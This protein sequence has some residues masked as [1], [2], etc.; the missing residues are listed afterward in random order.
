[1]V[2]RMQKRLAFTLIELLVVI[3]IIAI[4]IGLLLPAV[5]KVREAAARAKCENQLKQIAL[6]A[7]NYASASTYLPPGWMGPAP[8]E[9]APNA[10]CDSVGDWENNG[11]DVSSLTLLL[12]YLEQQNLYGQLV[13]AGQADGYPNFFAMNQ[14]PF[15]WWEWTN[16][17]TLA[18]TQIPT[19]ICPSD[20]PY[21]RTGAVFFLVT[22]EGINNGLQITGVSFG[23]TPYPYG[24]TNYLGVGGMFGNTANGQ[25]GGADPNYGYPNP[26]MIQQFQGLMGNRSKISLE[27]LT[28]ADGSANTLMYGE[29]CGDSDYNALNQGG[30]AL[31]WMGC[32]YF[33]T[34]WGLPSGAA[35]INTWYC[36]SSRHSNVVQ[37]AMGD[38]AVRQI[39]KPYQDILQ[40]GN[41]LPTGNVWHTVNAVP[42]ATWQLS[43]Y[44]GWEEGFYLDPSFIGN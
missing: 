16:F 9:P 35:S 28:S 12:P 1:M 33:P 27:Q 17:D 13:A 6:A 18:Q 43:A 4:L 41:V 39:K 8:N 15:G 38:G 32:G 36:F 34:A 31:S 21:L 20:T 30:F 26:M 7:H 24:R 29:A 19:F 5:Q 25:I 37:F 2:R 40:N 42:A 11:Q 3:A 22:M 23:G 44:G 14:F 10:T